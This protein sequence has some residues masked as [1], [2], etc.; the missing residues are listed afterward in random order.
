MVLIALAQ[1]EVIP[2]HPEENTETILSFIE[3]AKKEHADIIIFPELAISGNMLGSTWE[4]KAFLADCAYWGEK[5]I[6]ASLDIIVVFGNIW[7]WHGHLFDACFVAQNGILMGEDNHPFPCRVKTNLEA[8]GAYSYEEIYFSG[9]REAADA[10]NLPIRQLLTPVNVKIGQEKLALACAIGADTLEI[11]LPPLRTM[12]AADNADLLIHIGTA[13]YW[14]NKNRQYPDE[15]LEVIKDAKKPLADVQS[16]G[17]QNTGKSIYIL[18]GNSTL[19]SDSCDILAYGNS[20]Q[21]DLIYATLPQKGV[22]PAVQEIETEDEIAVLYRAIVY[23]IRR[24]CR[25][26]HI[27]RVVIGL[28]GGIDSAVSACLY[29]EAL[30]KENLR[31]V[32]MPGPYNSETTQNIAEELAQN[33]GIAYQ[34]VPITESIQLTRDQIQKLFPDLAITQRV[35]ENIQA[36]DRSTR[37]LAAVAAAWGGAFTCN[38]N[39]AEFSVGYATMYGDATGFFAALG[40]LW[41]YQ[42]YALADYIN[43]QYPG[44]IPEKAITIPPS[45]ELSPDQAVD[46][47]KGDPLYYPYHDH[48]IRAFTEKSA[49]PENILDWYNKGILAKKL[50]C[51]QE[52]LEKACPTLQKLIQDTETWW[53]QFTGMGIAKR[54]QG[55]PVLALSRSSVFSPRME[56][57]NGVYFT[58]RYLHLKEKLLKQA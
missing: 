18:N 58:H 22:I 27:S 37:I 4:D 42:V 53:K 41:K 23:A 44:L 10:L 38:G 48:L 46:E 30:G 21:E 16:I 9:T 33:L 24:F 51:T 43:T 13:P 5:V 6:N 11:S 40:D 35:W 8:S 31:S 55:P 52:A 26:C 54:L 15:L 34:V 36:R 14:V 39:K 19:Y 45:A 7:Q 57:Q 12:A 56:S 50:G 1:M 20:F 17:V 29:R 25:T 49:N 47:G 3:T 28:S 2:G 32:N